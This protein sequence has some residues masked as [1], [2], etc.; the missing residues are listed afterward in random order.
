MLSLRGMVGALLT[1]LILFT[2]GRSYSQDGTHMYDPI[3]AGALS[4]CGGMFTDSRNNNY[5]NG[6]YYSDNYN[7]YNNSGQAHGQSGP[8]VWYTFSVSDYT[9]VHISLCGS[10]FDTYV[11]RTG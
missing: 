6:I 9:D 2:A 5:T 8:D 11:S 4:P 3:N 7:E 10:N 1:L